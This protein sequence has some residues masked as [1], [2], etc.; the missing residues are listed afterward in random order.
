MAHQ[1]LQQS[2]GILVASEQRIQNFKLDNTGSIITTEKVMSRLSPGDP[3]D[4][5]SPEG[6]ITGVKII[7]GITQTN[8]PEVGDFNRSMAKTMKMVR[9]DEKQGKDVL[10]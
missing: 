9:P 10:I 2:K 1:V 4:L 6:L 8:S 5:N 3:S 7:R